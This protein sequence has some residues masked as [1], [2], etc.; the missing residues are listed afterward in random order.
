MHDAKVV[1]SLDFDLPEGEG[2]A[3]LPPLVSLEQMIKRSRQ[4]REWFPIG[5]PTPEERWRAKTDVEFH[6]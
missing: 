4:L 6:L 1:P 5:I 2:I 3:A